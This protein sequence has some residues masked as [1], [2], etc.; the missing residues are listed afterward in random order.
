MTTSLRIPTS[1]SCLLPLT[2]CLL[3]LTSC[4]L[5][6][7]SCPPPKNLR[8]WPWE[9]SVGADV[10]AQGGY[11]VMS[12][13][14]R[15]WSCYHTPKTGGVAF[16]PDGKVLASASDD[17]RFGRWTDSI[18][19]REPPQ[20]GILV[21]GYCWRGPKSACIYLWCEPIY[22]RSH[23]HRRR[24]PPSTRQSIRPPAQITP[25]PWSSQHPF[26]ML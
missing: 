9:G 22:I 24:Q 1:L 15:W 26:Q 16:S 20:H 18:L 7:I 3:P 2:S 12:P 5:P 23:H 4:L 10:N 19:T 6:L 21:Y 8:R 11:T 17:N 14:R 25:L 13:S